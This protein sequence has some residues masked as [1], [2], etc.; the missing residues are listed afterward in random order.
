VKESIMSEE[1]AIQPA[2]T[3]A[4]AKRTGPTIDAYLR[5]AGFEQEIAKLVGDL[6]VAKRFAR[7]ALTQVMTPDKSGNLALLS[8]SVE[9][10]CRCLYTV[11]EAGLEPGRDVYLIPRGKDCTVTV[12][13]Q[14]YIRAAR[15]SGQIKRIWANVIRKGDLYAIKGGSEAPAIEHT[16]DLDTQR[17][18]IIG[19]YACAEWADGTVE[20][21]ILTRDYLDRCKAASTNSGGASPWVKWYD[22]MAIKT[23]IKRLCERLPLGAES[24]DALA[25]V[26]ALDRDDDPDGFV[27]EAADPTPPPRR[28]DKIKGALR[29][30]AAAGNGAE[31]ALRTRVAKACAAA[32]YKPEETAALVN[33]KHPG[34]TLDQLTADDLQALAA[35]AEEPAIAAAN[36]DAI[37]N[38]AAG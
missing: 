9:S 12:K 11:A 38:G 1:N 14:G 20:P 25:K 28:T 10:L 2:A 17:G 19:A 16:W 4:P 29:V 18:D 22:R 15:A 36:L 31:A 6:Q 5:G 21:E 37:R 24:S 13:W 26:E 23:A 33:A 30:K 35:Q 3:T 8:C 27:V 34:Q 32:G 7:V